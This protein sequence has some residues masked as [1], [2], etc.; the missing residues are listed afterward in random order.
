MARCSKCG[1]WDWP[2]NFEPVLKQAEGCPDCNPEAFLA[3][4]ES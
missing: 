3:L 1:K 4:P 2:P